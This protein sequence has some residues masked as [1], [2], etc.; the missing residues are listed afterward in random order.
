MPR[1]RVRALVIGIDCY[2]SPVPGKLGNAISDATAIHAALCKIPGATSTLLTD[3]TKAAFEAA[4]KDFRDGTG[5]CQGRGMRVTVPAS[6]VPEATLALLFF[7]GHGIQVSGRNYLVPADFRMPNRNDKL[8]PM[9]RDTERACVSLDLIEEYMDEADVKA[10]ALWLDC[11][12]NVPDFL[13][14]LGAKRST[15]GTR[16]LPAGMSAAT[17]GTTGVMISFAAAPGREAL[18]R[19]TRV[20]SHSPFT[21][22][23]LQ[24]LAAPRRLMEV[25]PFLTDEVVADTQGK[26]RP[27]VGGSYGTLAGN[28]VL[29]A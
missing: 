18:D 8:E 12:R 11:C 14:E 7:A 5:T 24:V 22:A 3:C 4:L 15:G 28:L 25:A 21:A 26:Q 29:G 9:L 13:A 1:T 17:P 10:A 20:P 27:H 23:L 19:S 2:S 6:A 16:A